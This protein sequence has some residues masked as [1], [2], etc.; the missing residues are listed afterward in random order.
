MRDHDSQAPMS[1]LFHTCFQDDHRDSF[2]LELANVIEGGGNTTA[3]HGHRLLFM[4]T[5][6]LRG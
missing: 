2:P 6:K 5:V 3:S 4:S 1:L